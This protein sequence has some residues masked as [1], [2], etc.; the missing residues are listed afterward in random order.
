M[1][2][3]LDHNWTFLSLKLIWLV[4][5]PEEKKG[6]WSNDLAL[7]KQELSNHIHII[8]M[9]TSVN[10]SETTHLNQMNRIKLSDY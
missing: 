5:G 10:P 4:G 2:F 1:W 3:V 6:I 9:S 8:L 7:S